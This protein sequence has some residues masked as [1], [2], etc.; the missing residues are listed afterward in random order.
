MFFWKKYIS[1]AISVFVGALFERHVKRLRL[2]RP[3]KLGQKFL[4]QKALFI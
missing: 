2:I 1:S 4:L 3:S